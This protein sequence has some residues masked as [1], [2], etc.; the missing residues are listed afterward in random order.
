MR[1]TE[2]YWADQDNA[3][4][5]LTGNYKCPLVLSSYTGV[6]DYYDY[7]AQTIAPTAWKKGNLFVYSGN[8]L[9]EKHSKN[10]K[11]TLNTY[12]HNLCL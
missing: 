8:F 1:I 10:F 3:F 7:N 9:H 5:T 6:N 4:L 2:T 11:Y 12:L